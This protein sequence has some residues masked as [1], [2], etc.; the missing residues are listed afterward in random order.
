[1]LHNLLFDISLSSTS[2]LLETAKLPGFL[3][4]ASNAHFFMADW[5]IYQ[6]PLDSKRIIWE[7]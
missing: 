2:C 1:M 5:H 7:L 6:L 4:E 3:R